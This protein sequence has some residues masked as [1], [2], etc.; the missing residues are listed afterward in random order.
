MATATRPS[1][2]G[3]ER[4]RL[5]ARDRRAQLLDVA[6]GLLGEG[7][8]D[9]VTMEGVAA[10]AGVS[11]ALGYRHFDNADELLLALYDRE[12]A[13]LRHRVEV[14]MSGATGFEDKIGASLA[15]LLDLLTERGTAIAGIIQVH[16]GA[17]PVADRSRWIHAAVS[18]VY[19][20]MAVETYELT[21]A[22]A[23]AAAS[24]LLSGLDGLID[25]WVNHGMTRRELIDIYTTMCVASLEALVVQPPLIGE[26]LDIVSPS[27]PT[28]PRDA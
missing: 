23:Q 21:P 19:G 20:A 27:R 16:P 3:P 2:G 24:I 28:P 12:M 15:A 10:G 18:E 1:S 7:G 5:S 9:V 14:A 11:K 17:G 6:L 13:D 26:P 4:R 8:P 25:R 22:T